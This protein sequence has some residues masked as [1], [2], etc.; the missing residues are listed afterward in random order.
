M[1]E[2]IEH[3]RGAS[4]SP[5][6][7][8]RGASGLGRLL[9]ERRA[10]AGFTLAAIF[11]V[12]GVVLG[13]AALV[14]RETRPL[15]I[16]LLTGATV[17]FVLGVAFGSALLRCYEQGLVRRWARR[18]LRLRYDEITEFTYG[19]TRTF[20]NGAYAGTLLSLTFRAPQGTIR[21]MA[22]VQNMDA[23]LDGLRDHIAE[24]IAD[25]MLDDLRRPDRALDE[26]RGLSAAGIAVPPLENFRAWRAASSISC[27]TNGFVACISI[28]VSSI[29]IARWRT[30][31]CS[32]SRS[33]ARISSLDMLLS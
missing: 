30:N 20:H 13:A 27:P 7:A 4:E 2:W 16:A 18:E 31:Q 32:A 14:N 19:A 10:K 23:D 3:Q 15:G 12:L 33:T 29:S 22:S 11:A 25:R 6:E 8:V 1:G 24:R 17:L 28:T 9:F 21:Y 5:P 26:R